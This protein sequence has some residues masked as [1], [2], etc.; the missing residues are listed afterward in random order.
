MVDHVNTFI[1]DFNDMKDSAQQLCTVQRACT[2]LGQ[3]IF[4]MFEK[5]QKTSINQLDMDWH[6]SC[7]L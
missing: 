6:E 7:Y 4:F 5:A 1:C 3:I 2:D